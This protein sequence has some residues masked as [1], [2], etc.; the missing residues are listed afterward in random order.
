MPN[1]IH[2]GEAPSDDLFVKVNFPG[3]AISTGE[4]A[5]LLEP[6][7]QIG[8]HELRFG[9]RQ[10]IYFY[11]S[12]T[13]L[14]D[15]EYVLLNQ[16]L[17][18]E[19]SGDSCPN[20]VSSYV[21]DG[22][23]SQSTWIRE[24]VY[25]DI[26]DSFEFVP[27]L[28]INIV[29]C[30]QSLVPYYTG[31][32]NFIT[33]DISSYW[34]LHIRFPGSNIFH[35]WSSL[36]NTDDIAELSHF[37]EPLLTDIRVDNTAAGQQLGQHL[38]QL[39]LVSRK[40]LFQPIT[41]AFVEP[42]FK[43]PYYEGFNHYHDRLWLGMYRRSETFSIALLKDI[44]H[45][46][47]KHR[48]GQVY[49]TPWKSIIIKDIQ[50]NTRPDWD[51]VLDKHRVNLRHALNELNWQTEDYDSL[52]LVL[53]QELVHQM[54]WLDTRTYK[55]CFGVKM[56]SKSG[57]WGSVILRFMM[58]RGKRSW[59]QVQHTRNFNPNS[60]DLITYRKR[61][62]RDNLIHVILAL[63]EDFYQLQGQLTSLRPTALPE[64]PAEEQSLPT[65][66]HQCPYC[67]TI[68]DPQW[69]DST[70]N[71]PAQTAFGDLPPHYCCSVCD[72]SINDFQAVSI[73]K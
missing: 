11:V 4:L 1:N 68:Y 30:T 55:L 72:A 8:I 61:V 32:L 6:L 64:P 47:L 66:L 52:G 21:A 53:K 69:G 17:T 10:Q 9:S 58:S 33:A 42:A 35:N 27:K 71:I 7:E 16:E 34:Y 59:F 62:D 65:E 39:A 29:D 26:L 23:F 15:L 37:L 41:N 70:Q 36:V 28:K 40:F 24:G 45:V 43:L 50:H 3:G 60:K 25:K 13:Q 38:E 5:G 67:K 19:I 2:T 57:I 20:I 31:N 49:S 73:V 51:A 18:Y 22:I 46:C 12:Q 14:E 56:H 63:C 54:N 48:I 44:C